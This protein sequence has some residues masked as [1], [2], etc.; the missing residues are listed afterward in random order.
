MESNGNKKEAEA[1]MA[2]ELH[3]WPTG[4]LYGQR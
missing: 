3:D 1:C 4:T 2:K